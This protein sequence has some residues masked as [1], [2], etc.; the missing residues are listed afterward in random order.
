MK[1]RYSVLSLALLSLFTG[2]AHAQ[3][4][5]TPDAS[6]VESI[7]VV[8]KRGQTAANT[9]GG[10]SVMSG[11]ALSKVGAESFADYL[12]KLPGVVFNAGPSGNSTAVIRGVGTSAGLDQGQGTTGYYINEIPLTEVGYTISIPDIDTFDV[13]RVEVLRGP[14]GS[15]YG[16]SS[17]GGAINYVAKEADA[18]GF[19]ATL[20][21]SLSKT[22]NAHSLGYTGK[23]MLNVPLI[24]KELA[25]RVVV[26]KREMPGYLDN[27]GIGKKGSND[28]RVTDGR[29]SLVWTPDSKTRVS[30]F[31]LWQSSFAD[32]ESYRMTRY[33]ELE[34]ST[35]LPTS[36]D[37]DFALHSARVERDFGFA[38]LTALA[39]YN[40]KQQELHFDYSPYFPNFMGTVNPQLFRQ[41]GESKNN[42][43]EVRLASP[44]G[45]RFEWLVGASYQ[46]TDKRF[47]EDISAQGANAV[48][49]PQ[50][51]AGLLRGDF[52]HW[53]F[54]QTYGKDK[55]VFGEVSVNLDGGWKLTAGGR[56]YDTSLNSR[57]EYHGV[58][59]PDGLIIPIGYQAESG[60]SPKLSVS[61]KPTPQT[62]YYAVASEGFR[63]G[64]ANSLTPIAGFTTPTGWGS[65]S[66]RNYELG[67]KSSL[68]NRRITFD[69]DVFNIDWSDL[70]VRLSRPDGLTYGTNAGKARLRGLEFSGSFR[71]TENLE[72]GVNY[73]Y[74]DAKLTQDLLQATVPLHKGQQL[75]GS[76]KNQLSSTLTY[77]WNDRHNASASLSGRYLSDAPAN[78]QQT[79]QRING[80]SQFDGRYAMWFDNVE[81]SLFVNNI[82][83]KRGVTFSYGNDAL[84]G[85]QQFV[86]RPR[87]AGVR[88]HWQL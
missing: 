31:S 15:L 21:T 35:A 48:L 77:K 37:L 12:G 45:G 28:N 27:I 78:L 6:Q 56:R 71:A 4:G 83:D 38:K 24:A 2:A 74:L 84:F 61:Y 19:D 88:L 86:I 29:V 49:T 34:R 53:G 32:D 68:L 1:P 62:M 72:L 50:V 14:Q 9:A 17:L 52:Y 18:G 40:K 44:D 70:Q 69:V 58:L 25:A 41:L 87:T 46:K 5:A 59:Y 11:E 30:W 10:A 76:S 26:V 33:G 13:S 51:G 85:Q 82:A 8:G 79:D 36:F 39:S 47:D 60:F 64:G 55:S 63:F 43:Y 81:L 65:D 3:A 20:E 57:S 67:V 54:S 66:L 73:T 23:A 80:F 7:V 75:P 16:A 42:N 22:V